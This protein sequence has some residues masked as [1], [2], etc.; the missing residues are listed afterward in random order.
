MSVK[1]I[2]LVAMLPFICAMLGWL[3]WPTTY[4]Y[5]CMGGV[6]DGRC[7]D[8][9]VRLNKWSGALFVQPIGGDH[10][11][12]L[13]WLPE[14]PLCRQNE[15]TLWSGKE[16]GYG[17][18][19]CTPEHEITWGHFDSAASR[20]ERKRDVKGV[21][22]LPATQ[23]APLHT[24]IPASEAAAQPPPTALTL[25]IGNVS[26]LPQHSEAPAQQRDQTQRGQE[27]N[28]EQTVD[29]GEVLGQGLGGAVE[30]LTPTQG[31]DFSNYLAHAVAS[32]KRNWYSIVPASVR[33][34]DKGRVILQFR[35]MHNGG[36]PDA[37]PQL[38][39]PSGKEP[40]DRAALSSVRASSP[41]EP[42]PP[43]FHGAFI[44]LRFIFLYNLPLSSE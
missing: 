40:L 28:E 21:V 31:V 11:H 19:S 2:V 5:G 23:V 12:D 32:I 1:R 29:P 22:S 27:R 34:G 17:D 41:F 10:L 15:P 3:V 39:G 38:M 24:T 20:A 4:R 9:Q 14:P 16:S 25:D 36:V 18:A 42:L 13:E 43:T 6:T 35:V 30:M 7:D 44:E 8:V 26:Q 37:D 33:N